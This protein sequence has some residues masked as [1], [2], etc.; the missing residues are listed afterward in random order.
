MTGGNGLDGVWDVHRTGGV[1]PPMRGI[2]RKRIENGR[3][4]TIALGVRLP[5]VVEGLTLRYPGG[6][7]VDELVPDGPD[8][9]GGTTRLFGRK[10]GTFRLTRAAQSSVEG[11]STSDA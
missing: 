5:F 4:W 1:L 3:G 7:L 2:V 6:G 11:S 10:V 9:Y 8:A